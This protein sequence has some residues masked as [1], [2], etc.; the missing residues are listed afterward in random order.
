MMIDAATR[1]SLELTVSASGTRAGSLLAAVDRTVTGA[2]ARLLAADLGAPLLDRAPDRGAARPRRRCSKAMRRTRDWLRR[3]LRALPDIGRALGRLAA[4]RG[5]PRD[6]G[7][8]RDGLDEARRLHDRL[9]RIAGAAAAARRIAARADRPWRAG[10]PARRALWCR[11]RRSTRR[12]GGY[13]AEGYDDAL[14]AL[15]ATGG[16]G[17]RAIA[18]ARGALREPDRHR[19]AEDPPQ[20]RARLPYRGAGAGM[21][22]S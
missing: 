6:L 13:I 22:T 3:Q 10:R 4:G 8:L 20:Q 15:R 2:G 1:E 12:Q 7:Q 19:D 9:A 11:R 16:E 18:G 5:S 14:D 21:P 17:R